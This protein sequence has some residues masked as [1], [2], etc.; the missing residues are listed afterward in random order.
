MKN[1]T[2]FLKDPKNEPVLNSILRYFS[3]NVSFLKE[4]KKLKH[5]TEVAH[6]SEKFQTFITEQSKLIQ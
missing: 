5:F 4:A 3:Y 1:F 6:F 2:E